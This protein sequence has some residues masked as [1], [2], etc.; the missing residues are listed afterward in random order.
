MKPAKR[1]TFRFKPLDAL[2]FLFSAAVL[3]GV[4]LTVYGRNAEPRMV[5]ITGRDAV[6]LYPLSQD[7]IVEVEG[8]LGKTLVRIKDATVKVIDSPC[9]DKLCI[10]M[11]EI[12][13]AGNWIACLPN[14]VFVRIMGKE[15]ESLDAQSY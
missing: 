3:I 6:L 9:P 15:E 8:P 1:L 11:G 12:Q 5:Q 13:R 7:R 14:Q 2:A 10:H 4:S